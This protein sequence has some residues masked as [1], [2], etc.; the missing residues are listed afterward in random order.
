MGDVTFHV[1][2]GDMEADAAKWGSAADSLGKAHRAV[3]ALGLSFGGFQTVVGKKYSDADLAVQ[4]MIELGEGRL[5]ATSTNVTHNS[6]RTKKNDDDAGKSVSQAGA[7]GGGGDRGAGA[8]PGS[9]D[10]GGEQSGGKGK[11]HYAQL[12]NDNPM[13]TDPKDPEITFDRHVDEKTGEVSWTPR[14]MTPGEG[15]AAD[16]RDV[17]RIPER[18]DRIIVT[19]V[20]GE[21]QITYVDSDADSGGRAT[22]QPAGAQW[23]AAEGATAGRV[24]AGSGAVEPGAQTP[25]Q[26]QPQPP[27]APQTEWSRPLPEGADIAVVEV[28]D[29]E[30]HLVFLDVNGSEVTQVSDTAL[31]DRDALPAKEDLR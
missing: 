12:L 23:Q 7:G 13:P 26:A 31:T 18:A 4:N 22:G 2:P 20:D 30:P 17:E 10:N 19:M 21:P 28:R 29:G 3:P 8:G 9:G 16:G 6:G 24:V 11:D 14:E 27:S 1:V 25:L 5:R 15:S